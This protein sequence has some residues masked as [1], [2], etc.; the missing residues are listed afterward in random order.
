[1]NPGTEQRKFAALMFANSIKIPGGD[2]IRLRI[3]S[4]IGRVV[5]KSFYETG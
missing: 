3:A 1:M 5:R 4:N 2:L